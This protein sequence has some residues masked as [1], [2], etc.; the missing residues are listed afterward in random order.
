MRGRADT[1]PEEGMTSLLATFELNYEGASQKASQRLNSSGVGVKEKSTALN[2][3]RSDSRLKE[4][5]EL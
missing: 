5:E 4:T 1:C 3:L 2:R